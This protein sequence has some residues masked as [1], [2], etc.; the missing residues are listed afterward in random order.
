MHFLHV[1]FIYVSQLDKEHMQEMHFSPPRQNHCLT[2]PPAAILLVEMCGICFRQPWL[3]S[4]RVVLI[5]VGMDNPVS[6]KVSLRKLEICY[7]PS[8]TLG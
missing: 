2:I 5:K 6:E 4:G 7:N 1:F 8:D 3:S